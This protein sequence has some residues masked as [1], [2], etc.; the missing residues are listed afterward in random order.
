MN[1]TPASR[2]ADGMKRGSALEES[3]IQFRAR[4]SGAVPTFL[5]RLDPWHRVFFRNLADFLWPL[6]EASLSLSSR[7]GVFWPDVL[8]ESRLP[9]WR[10]L[11]SGVYHFIVLAV[12]WGSARFWP[13]R[14]QVID[15]PV[16]SREQVI[17]YDAA[18]YL[19]PLDTGHAT[20][21][22]PQKG[23][24]KYAPQPI[25][26]VPPQADNRTQTIVTPPDVKL[27]HDVPL[28]NV[29]A[30][31]PASP[32]MPLTAASRPLANPQ[33][34]ALP[35]VVAPPADTTRN[36]LEHAPVLT[37]PV[38]APAPDV[39]A[40]LSRRSLQDT[41]PAVVEPPPTM[42]G[43][44][45][46]RLGDIN[47]GRSEVIA[48]AP[49]LPVPEQRAL[50]AAAGGM[51]SAGAVVPPPPSVPEAGGTSGGGR[52]IALGIHPVNPSGPVD[53]PVGNRRGTFAATPEGKP[54]AAGTP[55]STAGE[56]QSAA[57]STNGHGH[58]GGPTGTGGSAPP[59]LFVGAGPAASAT[60]N[61]GG[62]GAGNGNAA[63]QVATDPRLMASVTPPRVT[64]AP[65][66][67]EPADNLTELEQ[68]VFGTR[69]S[70][71][72]TL[73]MPNLN[74]A[75]G[76]W[77]IRFAEMQSSDDK[78]DLVAPEPTQKVDPGYPLEL[79]RR[80][81]QG[82]VTLYAVI[83]NDGSVGEVRVLRGVDDR[84]DQYAQAAF[85][86][87]HFRP[88]LKN[89]DPVALEAVVMIPFRPTRLKSGF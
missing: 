46:R 16:F 8:V 30:W 21:Q 85:S 32:A 71:S 23:E 89:G 53:A 36:Q 52:L 61:P 17:Y 55:D 42:D 63:G 11:E 62:R 83:R 19:P 70:Y 25:I 56:S 51:A 10:F 5:V 72:M 59:G 50:P 76:S 7:P 54:G 27:T 39:N 33:L 75:G 37:Q 77:V 69:K 2:D 43:A 60:P 79:M 31:P 12:L 34:P 24:P 66:R 65:R 80:N 22:S 40:A 74:S 41:Q 73:N 88:A 68:K 4:R 78:G 15:H 48:P 45:V 35:S 58:G 6:R 47:I 18:E 67:A 29:V 28:P 81:V 82:T 84:L 13:R 49:Q 26:S 1:P 64:S 9:W 38:I 87:W 20:P 57:A 14:P 86:R 44:G 3:A